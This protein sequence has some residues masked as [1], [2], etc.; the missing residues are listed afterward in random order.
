MGVTAM[1]A[2][3]PAMSEAVD[4]A[5]APADDGVSLV[6]SD[7]AWL[8]IREAGGAV[9]FEGV[10]QPGA[11]YE[12]PLRAQA[13]VLHAGNAGGVFVA[14]GGVLRGPIGGSGK[15]VKDFSLTPSD[16]R[17]S[18]PVAAALPSAASAASADLQSAVAVVER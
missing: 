3:E 5:T 13:P 16:L 2:A 7:E 8:R 14:V 1:D 6:I 4:V 15:V 12:V 10:L 17:D 18:L 9:L 11:R